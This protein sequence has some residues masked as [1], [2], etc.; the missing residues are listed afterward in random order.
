[1]ESPDFWNVHS[2]T[3]I[4]MAY[5]AGSRE[6]LENP[7][8]YGTRTGVC[9]DTVEFFIMVDHNNCLSSISFDFDGCVYTAACCNSVVRLGLGHSV[10]NV[11]NITPD[12]IIEYLQTL[13]EDHYHCAELCVGAFY[14]A[15]TDYQ[16]KQSEKKS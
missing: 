9:G 1:M 8:G 16:N 7:D 15:L 5:E 13:P 10:D 12:M 6:R 11:W 2:L 14:L 3:L 4:E